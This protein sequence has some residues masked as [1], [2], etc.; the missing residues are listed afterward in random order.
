MLKLAY[1]ICSII[2]KHRAELVP[3]QISRHKDSPGTREAVMPLQNAEH[4]SP[5]EVPAEEPFKKCTTNDVAEESRKM[6]E[7]SKPFQIG[8]PSGRVPDPQQM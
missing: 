3:R 2:G 4:R 8:G 1:A 7:L 6:Q 5:R